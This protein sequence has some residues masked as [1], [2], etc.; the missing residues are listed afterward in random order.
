M[1]TK[2]SLAALL[3]HPDFGSLKVAINI[4]ES[5]SKAQVLK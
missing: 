3:L 1:I 5:I 2:D 4:E